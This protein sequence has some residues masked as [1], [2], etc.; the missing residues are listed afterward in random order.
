MASVGKLDNQNSIVVLLMGFFPFFYLS[1]YYKVNLDI[2][3]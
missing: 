1:R 3:T 2:L